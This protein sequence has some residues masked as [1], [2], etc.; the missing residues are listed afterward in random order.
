LLTQRLRA[1]GYH[2]TIETAGTLYREVECDLVSISPKLANST[3]W[4]STTLARAEFHERTR[5]NLD[6]IRSLM[7]LSDYQL[8]FVVE[9]PH[10]LVEIDSILFQLEHFEP[11]NVLLMPQGVTREDLDERGPWIAE[12]CKRRGFRYCPRLHIELYGNVR[13]V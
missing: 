1:E 9:Q 4:E 8:K 2:L 12:M 5:L 10:D 6:V 11:A 7:G 3:P 13:G